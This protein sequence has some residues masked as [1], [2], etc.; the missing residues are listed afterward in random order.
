MGREDLDPTEALAAWSFGR[1]RATL[2]PGGHIN[3][4]WTVDTAEGRYILQWL[5]PVFAPEVHLDIE[6]I[7]ARLAAEGLI[8]PRLVHTRA[9]DLWHA[10][11]AGA[12]WRIFTHVEGQTL[13]LADSAGRCAE[14]GRLLGAFHRA[15]WDFEHT[16][17]FT[18]F[19]VHDTHKH[20][21]T[22]E[23]ALLACVD[24]PNFGAVEPLAQS[25]L[26]AADKLELGAELPKRLVHGDPKISNFIFSAAGRAICLVDLDTL[27]HMPIAVELGDAFRSWC[28][29]RGEEV[30]SAFSTEFFGAGL[31]G[32]AGVVGP[33]PAAVEREAI[34][35]HVEIIAVELAARFCADALNERYFNW[36]RTAY[37]SASAHNLVRARSQLHLA[38]SVRRSR[39]EM[40][41]A[42]RQAWV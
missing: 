21:A 24:H 26:A 19:A 6:A 2:L 12:I 34:P 9:G 4:T 29:P 38:D 17:H 32:Y 23:A 40:E 27:A 42:V 1:T 30:E 41:A 31:Q 13:L 11:E 33:R 16:F 39:G 35:A 25:I 15:L 8:T 3:R 28:N 7:T 5:N 37:P 18:R 14:A 36:D 10:D 20:L 22:L